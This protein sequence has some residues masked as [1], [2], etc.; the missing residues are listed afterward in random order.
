MKKL[1][2]TDYGELQSGGFSDC[3]NSKVELFAEDS[4]SG[5]CK[6]SSENDSHHSPYP[7]LMDF[8]FQHRMLVRKD[9]FH[10]CMVEYC[11]VSS[12]CSLWEAIS[13]LCSTGNGIGQVSQC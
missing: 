3:A 11:T 4:V 9:P 1:G 7:I 8:P 2:I 13:L 12:T 5:T 10:A 6:L